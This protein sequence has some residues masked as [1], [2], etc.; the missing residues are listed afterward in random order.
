ML[1]LHFHLPRMIHQ[2][3]QFV[4]HFLRTQDQAEQPA[5]QGNENLQYNSE[6]EIRLKK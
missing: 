1:D 2:E 4:R 6:I 3:E 5:R